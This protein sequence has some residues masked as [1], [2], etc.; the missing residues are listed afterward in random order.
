MGVDEVEG[1]VGDGGVAEVDVKLVAARGGVE[2]GADEAELAESGVDRGE[3]GC[4]LEGEEA[5]NEAPHGGVAGE[6]AGG[7]GVGGVG[8]ELAGVFVGFDLGA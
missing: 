1:G 7:G 3:I 5:G 2:A 8:R 6:R 4:E